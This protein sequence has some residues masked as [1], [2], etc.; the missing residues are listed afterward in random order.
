MLLSLFCYGIRYGIDSQ[1]SSNILVIDHEANWHI[2][3][4]ASVMLFIGALVPFWSIQTKDSNLVLII[5][6][7][8]ITGVVAGV[9]MVPSISAMFPRSANVMESKGLMVMLFATKHEM[10]WHL[11]TVVVYFAAVVVIAHD[12]WTM[13]RVIIFNR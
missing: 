3:L 5:L 11:G 4:M 6:L 8:I 9:V 2:S 1:I 13:Y 12:S 10:K 7:P